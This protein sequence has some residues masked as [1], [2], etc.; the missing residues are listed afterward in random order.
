[1]GLATL[2]SSGSGCSTRGRRGICDG[3]RSPPSA[4][5]HVAALCGV[6]GSNY[7]RHPNSFQMID[8]SEYHRSSI[9]VATQPASTTDSGFW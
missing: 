8:V 2:A 9:L 4:G 1:M 5:R 7:N 6:D 3:S